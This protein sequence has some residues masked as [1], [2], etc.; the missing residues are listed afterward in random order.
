MMTMKETGQTTYCKTCRGGGKIWE[1]RDVPGYGKADFVIPCPVCGGSN[2]AQIRR[3]RSNIKSAFYHAFL[4]EFQWDIYME[5]EKP[6]D[7]RKMK[8]F[9]QTFSDRF[10]DWQAEGKG[11]YIYSKTRGSGKTFL[12]S[13]LCNDVMEKYQITA[14]F[15][16]AS[17]LVTIAKGADKA[18]VDDYQRDPISI[19]QRCAL[20]A[21]DDLGQASGEWLQDIL[22]RILDARMNDHLP[23]IVTSNMPI[24]ELPFDDRIIDRLNKLCFTLHLPDYCVRQKEAN[25]EKKAFL[26]KLGVM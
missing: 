19:F 5:D 21:I 7:L 16:S 17:E 8:A 14:K 10:T 2:L 12:A 24:S 9:V 18:A 6:V 22:F 11:F 13:C 1:T 3:E 23:I 4:H 25:G 26:Q 20:L 15:V